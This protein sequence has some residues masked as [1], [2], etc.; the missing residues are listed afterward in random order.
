MT[1]LVQVGILVNPFL[2][3]RALEQLVESMDRCTFIMCT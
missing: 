2:R 3:L 1:R